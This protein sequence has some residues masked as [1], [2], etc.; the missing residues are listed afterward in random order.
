[1]HINDMYECSNELLVKPLPIGQI[2]GF[3]DII[4]NYTIIII[5][6]TH[7]YIRDVSVRM[8]VCLCVCVCMSMCLCVYVSVIVC[9]HV[10]ASL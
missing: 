10:C 6:Y 8:S 7:I 2:K 3:L 1:M 4:P 9:V 5:F